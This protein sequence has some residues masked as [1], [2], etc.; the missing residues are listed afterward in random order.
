MKINVFWNFSNKGAREQPK[1]RR[2][3]TDNFFC[4]I[5]KFLAHC[6]INCGT[7]AMLKRKIFKVFAQIML[8]MWNIAG[9]SICSLSKLIWSSDWHINWRP[10]WRLNYC[11]IKNLYWECRKTQANSIILFCMHEKNYFPNSMEKWVSY[12]GYFS[13]SFE[14]IT[15]YTEIL[16]C[17]FF[18]SFHSWKNTTKQL[19]SSKYHCR[20]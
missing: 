16:T 8:T 9:N 14:K 18:H 5:F 4:I 15:F 11:N 7:V 17:G 2:T 12:L 19:F 20:K 6:D 10:I 3:H 1:E 13:I